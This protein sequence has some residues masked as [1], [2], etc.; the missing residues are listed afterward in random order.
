MDP[1]KKSKRPPGGTPGERIAHASWVARAVRR[2]RNGWSLRR[3]AEAE[4]L[5]H[6]TVGEA[7]SKEFQRVQAPA[8][9]VAMLRAIQRE[10]VQRILATWLPKARRGDK[11]AAMVAHKYLERAAKLDGLDAPSRTEH[12]GASGAPI[13]FTFGEGFPDEQLSALASGDDSGDAP[14]V[15]GSG[16][17]GDRAT[18]EED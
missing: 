9:E 12:T 2:S 16:A 4:G 3:I 15:E 11:D 6:S 7:L 13:V 8:E 18:S 14:G 1:D 17:G 5:H 10:Q